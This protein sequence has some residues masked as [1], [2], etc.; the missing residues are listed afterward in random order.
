MLEMSYKL[1]ESMV[2]VSTAE[3]KKLRSLYLQR[4]PGVE[5]WQNWVTSQVQQT[6]KLISASGNV[7]EFLGRR[8]DHSTK[9]A[10]LA[11][12]PQANTA[13]ATSLAAMRIWNDA[14]NRRHNGSLRIQ[15]LHQ[16][17]DALL[18]QWRCEDDLWARTK[19]RECFD[20]EL[21]IAGRNL[22]IPFEG[23]SGPSWG[24]LGPEHGGHVI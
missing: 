6:G 21:T 5:T 10:A 18:L 4:Y 17:H 24:E 3:A 12:E 2:V 16:I 7:H 22:V 15:I 14:E 20:N 19:I 1:K 11:F 23:A 8:T 9:L 13:H